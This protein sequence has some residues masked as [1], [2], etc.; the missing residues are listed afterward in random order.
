L[1]LFFNTFSPSICFV[2]FFNENLTIT[3]QLPFL[4]IQQL[5]ETNIAKSVLETF[6]VQLLLPRRESTHDRTIILSGIESK[7]Q[8]ARAYI[9][10]HVKHQ[11]KNKPLRIA[12]F[13]S[14][15]E[16]DVIIFIIIK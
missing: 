9:E 5:R 7:L 11:L 3:F 15:K 10:F 6:Q 1:V 8:K 12:I 2:I 16:S 4:F 13:G 14:L